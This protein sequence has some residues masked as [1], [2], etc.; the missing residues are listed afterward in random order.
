MSLIF[1]QQTY[2]P[3][4]F[5]QVQQ[6]LSSPRREAAPPTDVI[7]LRPLRVGIGWDGRTK[8]LLQARQLSTRR[9]P[10]CQAVGEPGAEAL[11]QL[12]GLL[13]QGF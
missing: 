5:R 9:A 8:N 7:S 11:K 4:G 13:E 6:P 2:F 3:L 1:F 12:T 10:C